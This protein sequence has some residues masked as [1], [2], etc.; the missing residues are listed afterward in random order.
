[1]SKVSFRTRL[2]CFQENQSSTRPQILAATSCRCPS[3]QKRGGGLGRSQRRYERA[4][5]RDGMRQLVGYRANNTQST[6]PSLSEH[7]I[8][9]Y[10][11][12]RHRNAGNSVVKA[13]S[14]SLLGAGLCSSSILLL[15]FFHHAAPVFADSQ[16]SKARQSPERWISRP[17]AEGLGQAAKGPS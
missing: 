3:E 13:V 11:A 17:A 5:H 4:S 6:Q 12:D 2:P 14:A 10:P 7:A 1:M 9:R 16:P 15:A 8:T